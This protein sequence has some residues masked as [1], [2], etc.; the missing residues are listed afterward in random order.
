MSLI[1]ELKRRSLFRMAVLDSNSALVNN[2]REYR[3]HK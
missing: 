3:N 1:A 2:L